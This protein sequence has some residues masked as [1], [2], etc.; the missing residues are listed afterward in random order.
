MK[1]AGTIK[2]SLNKHSQEETPKSLESDL[3]NFTAGM[4]LQT[5]FGPKTT[6]PIRFLSDLILMN[7]KITR[8]ILVTKVLLKMFMESSQSAGQ[9][10]RTG[11]SSGDPEK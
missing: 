1:Y 5:L 4:L 11:R 3:N 7:G 2:N 6:I 8:T 9:N 10:C